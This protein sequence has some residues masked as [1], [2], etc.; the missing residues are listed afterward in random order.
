MPTELPRHAADVRD[1]VQAVI[2]RIALIPDDGWERP[3]ADLDWSC[4]ETAAHILDDLGGYAMQ[5]SG[6]RGHG[7]SYTP[8]VEGVQP[9]PDGPPFTFW[10]EED[11]GT[12]AIC[13][14]LDAVGGLLVAVVA[15]APPDR[16][17][18]HPYGNPDA[19][20][21]AAMGITETALH[22]YDILRAHG[23]D[24]RPDEAIVGRVL[25]RIFP[26]AARTGDAWHDL[27]T[28]TGRT[29]DTRGVSWRW[30]S[31]VRS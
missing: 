30:D 20:A 17:G 21:L 6:E 24:H 1:T 12:Q 7:D 11:G 2:D 18:W 27:L 10:P 8:L 25:D 19:T 9:R 22:A 16:I 13:Q 14:C 28:A 29:A 26:K 15:T 3:A 5:L 23:I 31:S 4:R